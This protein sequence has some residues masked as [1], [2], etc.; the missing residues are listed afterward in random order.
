MRSRMRGRSGRSYSPAGNGSGL[1]RR[2]VLAG[3]IGTGAL[4][5]LPDLGLGGRPARADA[6]NETSARY[7]FVYGTPDAGHAPSGTLAAATY[8]AAQ[9]KSK[10]GA[11][12][13]PAAVTL[14]SR[15]SVP[16]AVN[17]AATPVSSPDQAVTAVAT[18]AMEHEGAKVTLTLLDAT[19]AKV[20]KQGSVT[21]KGV[22]SDANILVTPVFTPDSSIV[23]LVLAI[24]TPVSKR[25]VHKVHPHT[26]KPLPRLATTWT[27]HHALA[28]F[29]QR[30]GSMTG[31]FY[32]SDEPSLALSTAAANGSELLLWTTREPQPDDSAALRAQ[33]T[34][35]RLSVFPLGSGK[36]RLSVPAPAPWPGGEPVVTLPA[37]DIA[38]LVR[39]SHVQVCAVK[40][41]DVA[42]LGISA[43]AKVRARPSAVTM[44]A[45]PDG[46]VFLTKPGSGVAMVAD[47][48]DSFRP[49]A[50]VQFSPPATPFG[51]PWS[52]AV[53]SAEGDTLYVLGPANSG[54]LHAYEV[55]SGKLTASY[56]EGSHYNG[57]HQMPGGT[58]LAVKPENPR[59]AFFAP[60]LSPLG[61][62]DT[63]LYVSAIF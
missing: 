30:S 48:A 41:G 26:G 45:R 31:P 50:Q 10:T 36:A 23:S 7:T 24:S 16:V 29:D 44:Q 38:R 35:S 62:A 52:K 9:A 37:G 51:A 1:G 46:T 15:G 27:S 42:E 56:S 18:V 47:P 19:S 25:M 2:Q 54:G 13:S 34:L 32:L 14:S 4:L 39:G 28:Y 12:V 63:N 5:A 57:L 55:S 11:A 60:D 3:G 20:A 22:P 59:L 49:K 8:P 6:S 53:L 33:A 40:T 21:L 17:L 58:L 43:F 61:T